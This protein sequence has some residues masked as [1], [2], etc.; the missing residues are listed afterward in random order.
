MTTTI[1]EERYL[2]KQ[3][4]QEGIWAVVRGRNLLR[5]LIAAWPKIV[6]QLVGLSV[7]NTYATYFCTCTVPGATVAATAV[8][9]CSCSSLLS[10]LL[11]FSFPP[12]SMV[13]NMTNP[14]LF[15]PVQY[16]G[17]KDPFLVTVILTSVQILSMLLTA[18][19]TDRF[20]RRPLTD[21]P[22]GVTVVSVLCLGIIGCVDY[23]TKATSSLLV[24][25]HL[26]RESSVLF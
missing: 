6:Q 3:K 22:Y 25:E 20:G 2:A 15:S 5:S 18:T 12:F 17:N 13:V 7:F 24:S 23:T 14:L 11:L 10:P 1:E 26:C 8:A 19:L 9:R 16:A 4:S 21:Y